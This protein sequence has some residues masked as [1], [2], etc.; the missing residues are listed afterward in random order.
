MD[1]AQRLAISYYET[2]NT[3]NETHK[4]Y[5]VKHKETGQICV[6]KIIDVYN[7][8]VYR[9]LYENPISGIPKIIAYCE[10][11][12]TS[13]NALASGAAEN[14]TQLILIEEYISGDSL[15]D[16]IKKKQL[17]KSDI[18]SYLLDICTILEQLHAVEP[19]IIHR[20]IKPSNIIISGYNKAML[21]D[22]N[23]A[24]YYSAN[25]EEDTRLLGTQ[26]YAAPE[27]FGFGSSSPRTDI[28]SLGITLKEMLD[29]IPYL[30]TENSR[31]LQALYQIAERCCP[32]DAE[33]RY[34]SVAEIKK[35]LCRE[36][37]VYPTNTPSVSQ[38]KYLLPGYRTHKAW[39][40][41]LATVGYLFILLLSS[42]LTVNDR[43]GVALS[44]GLLLV[45][46]CFSFLILFCIILFNFNYLN[47]KDYFPIFQHK[48]P[49]VR[50][51]VTFLFDII[52]LFL[53]VFVLLIIEGVFS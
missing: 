31:D 44:G 14:T 34:A 51:I 23:A 50:W 5:L 52:I 39:K 25:K 35:A 32:I 28:Y 12:A 19:P 24:K 29:S 3:I 37:K 26:G 15:A 21:L 43:N 33:M 22:F 41:F 2:I 30:P 6:K 20:D 18:Q 38:H 16:L 42:S 40:A 13:E 53:L 7:I 46:K 27:Q 4:I 48:V 9:Y 1:I 17:R 36:Y 11:E 47:V 49:L 45:Y 8:D 10:I